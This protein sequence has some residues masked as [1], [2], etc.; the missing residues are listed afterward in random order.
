MQFTDYTAAQRRQMLEHARSSIARE[1]GYHIAHAPVDADW[2]K[3]E[4]AAFVTLYHQGELRGCIGSLTAYQALWSELEHNA[5][6]AAFDDPR[7]PPVNRAE[8][9]DIDVQISIL[10]PTQSISVASKDDLLSSLRPHIDGL[11]LE[12]DEHR[13]TFLP[14]VWGQLSD[15]AEFLNHLLRKAGLAGDYWSDTMRFSIYQ[16]LEVK[17]N[18][19]Q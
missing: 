16:V 9:S 17:E 7:F 14:Q 1:L 4:R 19:K 3:E 10:T 8:F 12:E 15:P 18:G 5:K 13:A 11:L 2:K 6:A